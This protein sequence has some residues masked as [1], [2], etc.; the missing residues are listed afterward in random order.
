MDYAVYL[1][2]LLELLGALLLLKTTIGLK[3]PAAWVVSVLLLIEKN[4]EKIANLF[5]LGYSVGEI[6]RCYQLLALSVDVFVWIVAAIAASMIYP[7]FSDFMVNVS[8]GFV[9]VSL[10]GMW[11]VAFGLAF[12]FA[13]LHSVAVTSQVR[14]ICRSK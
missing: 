1:L 4:K 13:A 10:F 5:C 2:L 9:P 7:L 14:R 3:S 8:P 6:A 11:G 12:L